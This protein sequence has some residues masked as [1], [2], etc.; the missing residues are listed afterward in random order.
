MGHIP[1]EFKRSSV[2]H[3]IIRRSLNENE[4][5][6]L[7]EDEA[8]Q[9]EERKSHKS[10]VT[11]R[12]RVVVARPDIIY[13]QPPE[14]VHRA[15]VVVHRPDV[16]IH[17]APVIVHRPSVIVHKPDVV[18]HQPP[19][20]FNTPNPMV[21]QPHT[22]SHDMY[23]TRPVAQYHGSEL[24]R[25][26]GM[27]ATPAIT[28]HVENIGHS[29]TYDNNCD[30]ND[31]TCVNSNRHVYGEQEFDFPVNNG[32]QVPFGAGMGLNSG[33]G[34]AAN[35]GG[36]FGAVAAEYGGYA[37]NGFVG[38]SGV[39]S[40]GFADDTG[41][42]NGFNGNAGI[43]GN[44]FVG[45]GGIVGNRF[46]GNGV[47]DNAEF[48][49][50]TGDVDDDNVAAREDVAEPQQE[51]KAE[52]KSKVERPHKKSFFGKRDKHTKATKKQ[53]LGGGHVGVGLGGAGLFNFFVFSELLWNNF[54]PVS[55]SP[56]PH[57]SKG[58]V[59]YKNFFSIHPI[60]IVFKNIKNDV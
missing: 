36:R 43:V 45:N 41:V 20:V 25:V 11:K 44:G 28:G 31:D 1:E 18:L 2:P 32:N 17:R 21:H 30:D 4:D 15:P 56:M 52:A 6:E 34:Y 42:G 49:A 8:E 26:G 13:H 29:V 12:H 7:D 5:E 22:V 3:K 54:F 27:M 16:V 10:D 59:L 47:A 55:Y 35:G 38:N 19:V 40:N 39:M 9:Q 53:T 58:E 24:Q 23:V 33:V 57:I 51:E 46:V 14:I 48:A 37:G 50:G 60:R